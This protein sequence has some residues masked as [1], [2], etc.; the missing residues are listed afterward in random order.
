MTI[1]ELAFAIAAADALAAL[2][3]GRRLVFRLVFGL[4]LFLFVGAALAWV[5]TT[6]KPWRPDSVVSSWAQAGMAYVL[7]L[8]GMTAALVAAAD[9]LWRQRDLHDL[10]DLLGR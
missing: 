7:A 5:V 6:V 1:A 10:H 3:K 4:A 2:L 8:L 9:L